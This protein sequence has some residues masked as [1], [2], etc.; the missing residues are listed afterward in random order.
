MEITDSLILKKFFNKQG[1]LNGNFSTEEYLQREFPE[2]LSYLK[3]RFADSE[4]LRETFMR[5]FYKIEKRPLCPI[6][7][8]KV[9]WRGKKDKLF[10][11]TCGERKCWLHFREQ[12]MIKRYGTPHLPCTEESVQKIRKTKK[13]RY[14]DEWYNNLPKRIETNLKKYGSIVAVN[15][16]IIKKRKETAMLH[17]GVDVPSKSKIVKDK[18]KETCLKRYGVDNYRKTDECIQKIFLSKKLNGTVTSSSY[19]E[20]GFKWLAETYGEENII[21]QYVD[22][23]YKNPQNGHLYHC[24]FYLKN[25]DIFIEFQIYWAHGPH[26]FNKDSKEDQKILSDLKLKAIN[27]PIYN[28]GIKEWT[29]IDVTKRETAKKNNLKYIEIFDRKITK[30]KLLNIIKEYEKNNIQT[31]F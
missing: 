1:R 15:D 11:D 21:R 22:T 2:I 14:G 19:E 6:C 13:E 17:Y 26:P 30:D 8:K 7:G 24:D 31:N 18:M 27:K 25:L 3:K 5:I 28:R 20:K 9:K 10:G 4:S 12:T 16:E 29:E 23:R